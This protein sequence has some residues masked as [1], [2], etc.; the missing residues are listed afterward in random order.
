M[1]THAQLDTEIP[2]PNG[3]KDVYASDGHHD[4]ADTPPAPPTLPDP[5]IP[6]TQLSIPDI[7]DTHLLRVPEHDAPEGSVVDSVTA[8]PPS[9]CGE[10]PDTK[11]SEDI[12]R[13]H[14]NPPDSH[15]M[16]T[17]Q[18][19][20]TRATNETDA[21][22][23][24]A[25]VGTS[26]V[27]EIKGFG[28]VVPVR[29]S[30][31][32]NVP[33]AD[34]NTFEVEAGPTQDDLTPDAADDNIK[35]SHANEGKLTLLVTN[36][37]TPEE[38]GKRDLSG[39]TLRTSELSNNRARSGLTLIP[40]I[41]IPIFSSSH[42]PDDAVS[43]ISPPH[44]PL[45]TGSTTRP[46]KRKRSAAATLNSPAL[47]TRSKTKDVAETSSQASFSSPPVST[48]S[49]GSG[50]S[51]HYILARQLGHPRPQASISST[52]SSYSKPQFRPY[53]SIPP[54]SSFHHHKNP[55]SERA[56]ERGTPAS[57]T[58]D[59]PLT[60]SQC[61]FHKV[62]ASGTRP[63][64]C[65]YLV[66]P[67][68]SLGATTVMEEES[69]V[70]C[71][72]ATNEDNAR[73]ITDL[74]KIE[75]HLISIFR[76]LVGPDAMNEGV[77]GYLP[78]PAALKAPLS[79]AL[80]TE[81]V[82]DRASNVPPSMAKRKNRFSAPDVESGE[83][84]DGDSTLTISPTKRPE[85][86]TRRR[87]PRRSNPH[88]DLADYQPSSDESP[89]A[90]YPPKKRGKR[91]RLHNAL[92]SPHARTDTS[93][94]SPVDLA[95]T[96]LGQEETHSK[97]PGSDPDTSR[98]DFNEPKA[99]SAPSRADTQTSH[100]IR[101][102]RKR[103]PRDPGSL[104]YR[105]GE[106]EES[107]PDKEELMPKSKRHRQKPALSKAQPTF[108]NGDADEPKD[109]PRGEEPSEETPREDTRRP[110]DQPNSPWIP[111]RS[112]EYVTKLNARVISNPD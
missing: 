43:G 4:L 76:K 108:Q 65:V 23:V 99:S 47:N 2:N 92:S 83:E 8:E 87:K 56:L 53:V 9:T 19:D 93:E 36:G 62:S 31:K 107:E 49:Q 89:N 63:E 88:S 109:S 106:D 78:D 22:A 48:S 61:R 17:E 44:T 81:T 45:E 39:E 14:D 25:S 91:A 40:E 1:E 12:G 32:G 59:L 7:E 85:R 20:G 77:C 46:G 102:K 84:E 64:S 105:P 70:D 24:H 96:A 111:S 34:K 97:G 60:R 101:R 110:H 3:N 13:R 90:G 74:S 27:Q 82:P 35:L 86:R 57:P 67:G 6:P 112:A 55:A 80:P 37:E 29:L 71:G 94:S 18:R 16:K 41:S 50:G 10:S 73:K 58:A 104:A 68:C 21:T 11:F 103:Q 28:H 33:I 51:R 42:R 38:L 30:S 72:I 100:T 52:H 66:I 69:I 26:G 79:L 54:K 98:D 15:G 95:G 5:F 75:P